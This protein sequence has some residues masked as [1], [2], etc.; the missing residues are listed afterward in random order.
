MAV[1]IGL[2]IP[3]NQ[4]QM[5]TMFCT[6][7]GKENAD[8]AAFCF[9]CGTHIVRPEPQ[10]ESPDLQE[11]PPQPKKPA[12]RFSGWWFGYIGYLAVIAVTMQLQLNLPL[13]PQPQS[14]SRPL[15][16]FFELCGIALPLVLIPGFLVALY[17]FA[18]ALARKT[19]RVK[20]S[21]EGVIAFLAV[22][23]TVIAFLMWLGNTKVERTDNGTLFAPPTS[24]YAVKFSGTP[25][26]TEFDSVT[27]AGE[28]VK[29]VRAEFEGRDFFQRAE[30]APRQPGFSSAMTKDSAIAM[31][32]AYAQPNGLHGPLF[33][34][35]ET[36]I[37]KR[38]SM[39]ATKLLGNTGEG[40]AVTY[41]A[42]VYYG[43]SSMFTVY[44]GGPSESYPT[45]RVVT[46]LNSVKKN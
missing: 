32:T 41:E 13:D 25:T 10:H 42:I 21:T 40:I 2:A 29:G 31:M 6:S 22:G 8:T 45:A 4:G 33:K 7:C 36:P 39:R 12:R 14:V 44:A 34:W 35:E 15:G 1:P 5:V 24:D 19:V 37:G 23:A 43:Y 3:S 30:V 27:I 18:K 11:T 46:F 9:A 17:V 28:A 38:L 26:I 16:Y 20:V